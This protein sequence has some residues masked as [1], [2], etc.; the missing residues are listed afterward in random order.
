MNLNFRD[1]VPP[2][3]STRKPGVSFSPKMLLFAGIGVVVMVVSL[4][5]ITISSSGGLSP[6]LQRLSVRLTVLQTMVSES[7]KSVT[8]PELSKLNSDLSIITAGSIARLQAPLQAAGMEKIGDDIKS[9][10]ADTATLA[11]LAD[12]KLTGLFDRTYARII[13]L[14]VD[15]VLALM[16]EIYAKTKNNSLREALS[17]TY[18]DFS[19]IRKQLDEDINV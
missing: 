8:D 10:E 9:A 19:T 5:L 18:K 7:K 4:I 14:K 13:T 11:K 1:E 6:Q 3:P 12:A 17:S 15:T 16:N 2:I